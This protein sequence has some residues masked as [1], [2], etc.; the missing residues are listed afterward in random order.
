MSNSTASA[1]TDG[2]LSGPTLG[3][4]LRLV[5]PFLAPLVLASTVVA[6]Q[7]GVTLAA[8]R[9]AG[10]VVDTALVDRDLGRLDLIVFALLALFAVRGLLNYW[11]LF[12]IR[13]TGARMLRMLR[14]MLF[15]HLVL[16]APDFYE[17]RRIGELLSRIGADL[18]RSQ[19]TITG[20]V[21][22]GIRSVLTFVGT[23]VIVLFLHATLTGIVLLAMTP[24]LAIAFTF[25][26]WLQ[27]LSTRT[28]D[29]LA[30]TAAVAEEALS[31]IRTVQA[32]NRQPFEGDRYR[33][34]LGSL[35][36]VQLRGAHLSGVFFAAMGF[37]GY[38]AF[39]VV[40]W[41]GGR[42]IAAGELS[43]GELTAFLLY[44]FAIAGS[45]GSMA[46]LYA[47]VRE[48]RGASARV[49]EILDTEPTIA[50]A[51]SARALEQPKGRVAIEDVSFRYPSAEEGRW[52]LRNVSL[53]LEPGEVVALVGPSGSGK[54]TLFSLI[55]RFYN[56]QEGHLALDHNPLEE[57]TLESAR[58]AIGVVPQEIFLF[59]GTVA[60]NIRYSALSAS[61]EEV[62][63]AAV[64]AGAD[65][66]IAAL[67]RGYDELIGER[68]I[69]LS[70]G[71]RQR[72]AIARAFLKRPAVLLLDEATSALD[73]ESEHVVQRALETLMSGRT[74]LIIAHRLATA[75]R[76]DRIAVLDRGRVA[77][78]GTH[79]E[80]QRESD[81]YR[82]YWEL[83]AL[84]V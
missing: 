38:G 49:F 53:E 26:R 12:L 35:L 67:P 31:G 55:L 20:A 42:L 1:D 50:D 84:N 36:D 64:A 71:Q 18:E 63:Q 45:V 34:G 15:S 21:P 69:R 58:A 2:S 60:D 65:G 25:G 46:R 44:M 59:S 27:R 47:G 52:A 19:Q 68:G 22:E 41:Y 23:M 81:I 24:M 33:K 32:F 56:P 6:L 30:D 82:R 37:F 16:L 73:A 83:Q 66:F 4:M 13:A 5:R 10:V 48:L 75:Q 54:S 79:E 28:Q 29:S 9:L 61:D 77:A 8:P 62:R 43:P 17:D 14:D 57:L 3:R 51:P 78:V 7:S 40:L 70:A 76:A 72:I 74:T 39:A 80:L 11:Q